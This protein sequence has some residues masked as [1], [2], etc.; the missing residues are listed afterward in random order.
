MA[1]Q[2]V[3]LTIDVPILERIDNMRGLIPRSTIINAL[4]KSGLGCVELQVTCINKKPP[5]EP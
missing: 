2:A 5:E 1:K 4:I 3:N